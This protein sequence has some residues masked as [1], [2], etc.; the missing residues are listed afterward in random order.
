MTPA[1]TPRPGLR[2]V[3]PYV[4]PQLAVTARLNTNECPVPLPDGFAEE[5]ADELATL[6]LNRYPDGQMTAPSRGARRH[7]SG[8]RSRARGR[9]TAR[10]RS[11][12]SSCRRTEARVAEP[13]C[14]SPPT[15]STRGSPGSRRP[16]RLAHAGRRVR[17][18]G[19]DAFSAAV[20]ARPDVVFVCSPNNPTGNAQP[21]DAS[22]RSPNARGAR[23]RRR[24]VHRVRRH[25][26]ASRSLDR[27]P[28]RRRDAHDVEGLRARGSADRLRARVAGGRAGPATRPAPVPPVRDHASRGRRGA[29]S[30]QGGASR[31]WT[32]SATSATGSSRRSARCPT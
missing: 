31:S 19:G 17:P 22:R 13:P 15:C 25:P 4:S 32:R 11:S 18:L 6:P 29:P 2:D 10:T 12:P 5:L 26:R 23:H 30:R 3:A 9:R 1:A 7:P 8:T 24:G 16:N 21:V 27:S 20:D 28:E 14:S